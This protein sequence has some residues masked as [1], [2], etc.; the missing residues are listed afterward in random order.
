MQSDPTPL[1]TDSAAVEPIAPP[2]NAQPYTQTG[3]DGDADRPDRLTPAV[4]VGV[5]ALL[6]LCAVIVLVAW[7]RAPV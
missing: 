3:I 2:S 6:L 1:V 7:N 5:M 4:A